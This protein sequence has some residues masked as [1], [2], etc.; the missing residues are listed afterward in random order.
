MLVMAMNRTHSGPRGFSIIELMVAL[1]VLAI[2]LVLATPMISTTL[3]KNNVSSATNS[4]LGSI[5]YARAEAISRGT[6]VSMCPTT[7]GKTCAAS[8]AYDTGWLIYAY[9]SSPVAQAAYDSTKSNNIL[10]RYITARSGVSIQAENTKVLTFGPQGEM[11][12][13]N[14][15]SA[16]DI[17]YQQASG[18]SAQSTSEVPGVLL[19][20]ESSGNAFNQTLAAG[21]ACTGP[22]PSSSI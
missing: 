11:K 2:F 14:T 3:E 5:N 16:F 1:A 21:A 17:C 7:D 12:P 13:D 10:L 20:L 18:G 22:A 4:L 6:Y 15:P 9:T 8:T 19:T